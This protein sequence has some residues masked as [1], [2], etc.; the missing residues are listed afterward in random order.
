MKFVISDIHGCYDKYIHMLEKIDLRAEDTLY[1]LGDVIDRYPDGIRILRLLMSLPN[2]HMLLGN[3]E[4]MMLNALDVL[5]RNNHE[6]TAEEMLKLYSDSLSSGE[7]LPPEFEE[8]LRHGGASTAREFIC[9][10]PQKQHWLLQYLDSLPCFTEEEISG[11]KYF[12][13]HTVPEKRRMLH[14]KELCEDDLLWGEPEYEVLYYKRTVIVT[15]H[16]PT[17][18][19]D[20]SFCGKIWRGNNHIAIDCGAAYGGRLGCIRLDDMAEFYV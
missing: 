7:N 17:N 4:Y 6:R 19:I 9:M 14:K 8:W 16:T 11:Q 1:V 13:A 18:L 10:S 12:L 3:H 5:D 15:G 20:G 2:V